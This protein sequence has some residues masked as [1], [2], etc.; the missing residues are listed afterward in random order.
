MVSP[1]E[2]SNL[3]RPQTKVLKLSKNEKKKDNKS[4]IMFMYCMG[5]HYIHSDHRRL[6]GFYVAR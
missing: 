1:A 5:L 6:R 3:E 4:F 2:R